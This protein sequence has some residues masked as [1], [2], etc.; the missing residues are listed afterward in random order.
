[1]ICQRRTWQRRLR[2]R[3]SLSL[4]GLTQ[5]KVRLTDPFELLYSGLSC[6]LEFESV[7]EDT[8]CDIVETGKEDETDE[9][10]LPRG[11]VEGILHT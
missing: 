5:R 6:V 10:Y 2:V 9:K 4:H 1:M 7:S 8:G 3:L 11:D